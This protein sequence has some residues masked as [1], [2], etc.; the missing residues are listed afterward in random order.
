MTSSP[1]IDDGHSSSLGTTE[2]PHS[3]TLDV[4]AMM[5]TLA[6]NFVHAMLT[7]I[8]PALH[9]SAW[10]TFCTRVDVHWRHFLANDHPGT[11]PAANEQPLSPGSPHDWRTG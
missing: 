4:N 8:H 2:A 6:H 3:S 1:A 7:D 11:L 5:D 9:Q 10:A